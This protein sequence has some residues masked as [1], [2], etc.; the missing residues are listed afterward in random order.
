MKLNMKVNMVTDRPI[1]AILLFTLPMLIGN[2]FQQLYVMVDTV[3]V[4]RSLGEAVLAAVGCTGTINYWV[5]GIV[6]GF[7]TGLCVVIS[8]YFGAKDEEGVK[9]SFA[10]SIILSVGIAVTVTLLSV[11][12]SRPL[13][14][15]LN[16][17]EATLEE[18]TR[19]LHVL[20]GGL[21]ASVVFNLAVGVIRALG[22]SRKA[23]YFL[24]LMCLINTLMDYICVCLLNMDVA[25]V[26]LASVLSQLIAG[27]LCFVFVKKKMPQFSIRRRHFIEAKGELKRCLRIA[28]PMGFQTPIVGVGLLALQYAINTL[29]PDAQTAY[30]AAT[31]IHNFSETIFISFG[32]TMCTYVAQNYG[33]GKMERIKKGVF[34]CTLIGLGTTG[35]FLLIHLFGGRMLLESVIGIQS[36]NVLEMGGSY[37]VYLGIGNVFLVLIYIFRNTLQGLGRTTM[38]VISGFVESAV[39]ILA[40]VVLVGM[41]AFG[42]VKLAHPLAW[43]GAGILLVFAYAWIM[44]YR[45]PAG[46]NPLQKEEKVSI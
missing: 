7:V 43:T 12:L 32:V 26:A 42:G 15:L 34:Q 8:Q 45:L 21:S 41:L 10:A 44:R 11:V 5:S 14:V 24:V 27:V 13:L 9:R 31:R 3:I 19:Y 35:V 1:K 25:G 4:N 39:R 20:F 33:A 2:L 18:A 38:P 28:L 16:T 30:T 37:L 40:A 6:T 46:G 22:E 23:L 36:A 29:G 17:P